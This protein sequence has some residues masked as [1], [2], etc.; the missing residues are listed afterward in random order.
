M[1]KI[2]SSTGYNLTLRRNPSDLA[3]VRNLLKIAS[4]TIPGHKIYFENMYEKAGFPSFYQSDT[5]DVLKHILE[6]LK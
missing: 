3:E 5:L 1:E 2:F 4:T 6:L